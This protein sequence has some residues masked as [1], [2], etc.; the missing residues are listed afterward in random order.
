MARARQSAA[1]V[2]PP[3]RRRAANVQALR[4]VA[5]DFVSRFGGLLDEV[6]AL[7]EA[8]VQAQEENGR[9][10]GEL[11]EGIDLFREARALVAHAEP[12]KRGSGR[13]TAQSTTAPGGQ[14]APRTRT[15]AAS[16][17]GTGAGRT[18]ASAKGRAT[19]A[20]V[21]PDV[22]LAVIGKLG[23][24]TAGEIAAQISQEGVPVS[25]RAIRHIAKGAGA[26]MR[27]GDEGR[28]VYSLS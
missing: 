1:P 21:T 24:A 10:R 15:R 23:S 26:V 18:R 6:V 25:G 20:S 3:R 28:V 14:A 12:T 22:V 5:D 19:P 27:P 2:Q 11:A 17:N 16:R 4:T 8:L 9:L 7:R 13:R